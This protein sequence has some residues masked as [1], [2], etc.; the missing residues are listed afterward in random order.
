MNRK[1]IHTKNFLL[2]LTFVL[3]GQICFSQDTSRLK[4]QFDSTWDFSPILIT[5]SSISSDYSISHYPTK[6]DSIFCKKNSKLINAEPT[7]R[8]H[9]NYHSLA[10][11]LWQLGRLTEAE[12]MFLKIIASKEPYYVGTYYNSSDIPGD[13]ST[14]S[15]GYGSYTFNYKNRASR[16]LSKIYIEEK[17][18]DQ[19]LKYIQYVDKKYTVEYSCGTGYMW[20]RGEIDGLYG[21]AYEG[22]GMFDSIINM[23]LPQYSIHSDGILISTLKKVHS[24]TEINEY[25]KI[26]ENSIV[27]VVDS[28][29]SS[30]FITENYGEKNESTTEIKYTSGTATMTLFGRLVTLPA[31]NL[32][33]GEKVSR[34]LFVKE[35]KESGF[36]TALLDNK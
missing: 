25:L 10:C 14:N 26:A 4:F 18:F 12:S 31:P 35:F 8:N 24:Q 19:A 33:N 7:K 2:T 9:I 34:D 22:L 15:Y 30:S 3:V 28:F 17:K 13:T 29:Q 16:Y 21:L 20:Y 11:S 27:C 36:Y 5:S 23:F 6:E 1:D 32:E